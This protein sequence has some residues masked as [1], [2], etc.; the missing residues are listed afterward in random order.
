MNGMTR[1]LVSA[2]V[3]A[4]V[5]LAPG[6]AGASDQNVAIARSETD[7]AAV[8]VASVQYRKAGKIVDPV[9]YA[10]AK[11]SCVGCQTVAAAFQLV[12]VTKDW[13]TLAPHNE[14]VAVNVLCDECLTWATAKQVIVATGGPASLTDVGRARMQ[15]LEV[16]I[17]DLEPRLATMGLDTLLAE[18]DAAYAELLAIADEEV[19]RTDGGP[20]DAEVVAARS[21]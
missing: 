10:E 3:A 1:I 2:V 8:V 18:L 21:A 5:V 13:R 9:N 20:Q 11:A 6:A 14:A 19:V 17:E 16:R 7:G 15:A 4:A 12:L